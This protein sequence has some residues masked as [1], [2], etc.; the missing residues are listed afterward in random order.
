ML[1]VGVRREDKNEWERRAPLTP[2]HLTELIETHGLEFAVQPSPIR[3]FPDRDYRAAG[4]AID[5]DLAGCRLILGIKEIPP[6]ELRAGKTYLYFSHTSK[7]QPHNMPALRRLLELGSTLLDYEHILD[8]RGRR[9]VFFG[10]FAG[11]AG[12]IDA[13]WALGR[14]YAA[15]G[16]Q[17]P[18]ESVRLAHDYSSLDEATNHIARV[19]ERLRHTGVPDALRPIVFGFTGSGNVARGALEIFDRLPHVELLPEELPQLVHDPAQPRN[20]VYRVNFRRDQRFERI[21]GGAS[22]LAEFEQNPERYRSSLLRWLPYLHVVVHGAWWK[23]AQPR[24]LSI[25]ELRDHWT[26]DTRPRLRLLA[27]IACDIGGGIEATVRATTPA[28]PVFVYDVVRGEA[29]DGVRGEGPVVLAIDNLPCQLPAE[30]SDHFGDTLLRFMPQ[31]A[32]CDWERPFSQLVLPVE[33]KNAIIVHGG[34]LTPRYGHLQ[35]HLSRSGIG[36]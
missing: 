7:G 26:G 8:E 20:V 36:R 19:G 21:E 29:L 33:I 1:R 3:V 34:E 18:F 22:D 17:T 27:D 9:L 30:S 11:Y 12:M 4:A 28:E 2:D 35:Q 13:L 32:G 24:L 25:A 6:S 31:L 16:H 5:E 10:R 15:E 23:P 14:R